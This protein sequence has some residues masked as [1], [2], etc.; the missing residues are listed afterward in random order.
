MW[1]YIICKSKIYD[2]ITPKNGRKG[3]GVHCRKVLTLQATDI[4]LFE[5]RVWLKM[6][7]VNDRVSMKKFKRSLNNKSIGEI[8]WNNKKYS[9]STKE[10]K[11]GGEKKQR[12][13]K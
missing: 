4:R 13:K 8:N 9:M 10:G 11:S 3:V 7:T 2:N 5:G 1:V 6:Y 12:W